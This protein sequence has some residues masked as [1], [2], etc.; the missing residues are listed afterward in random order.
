M[1]KQRLAGSWQHAFSVTS[2][3]W[4]AV[5]RKCVFAYDDQEASL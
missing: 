2:V 4:N 1:G 5:V 3:D